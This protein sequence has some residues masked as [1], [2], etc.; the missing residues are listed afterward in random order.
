LKD[1]VSNGESIIIFGKHNGKSIIIL[2]NLT[3]N[4]VEVLSGTIKNRERILERYKTKKSKCIFLNIHND[5]AG[6]RLENTTDIVFLD[7]TIDAF[8]VKQIIGRVFRLG[9][10]K[11]K[12]LL[13]HNIELKN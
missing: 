9:R 1:I 12:K 10:E 4:P 5:N 11:N 8:Y 2:E 6:I 13:L 7:N 3:E